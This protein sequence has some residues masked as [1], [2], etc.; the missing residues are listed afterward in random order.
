MYIK[1]GWAIHDNDSDIIGNG[2]DNEYVVN[3]SKIERAR[4]LYVIGKNW[5]KCWLS[6]HI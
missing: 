3:I 5:S 2:N 6:E 1:G 4:W